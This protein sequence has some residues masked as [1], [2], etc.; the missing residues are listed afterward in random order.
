MREYNNVVKPGVCCCDNPTCLKI[1]YSHEGMFT[2]PYSDKKGNKLTTALQCLGVNEATK[3]HILN[4]PGKYRV[5]P[6][7][8]SPLHRE[9]K[10]GRWHLIKKECYID[11]N[12][13]E[14]NVPPPNYD[15]E[16]YIKLEIP[17]K[18]DDSLPEWAPDFITKAREAHDERFAGVKH[19]TETGAELLKQ[20]KEK[21]NKKS[22]DDK[23]HNA[24]AKDDT[25]ENNDSRRDDVV[26]ITDQ[27][28]N[29]QLKLNQANNTIQNL[30][31]TLVQKNTEIQSQKREL[32]EYRLLDEMMENSPALKY[33]KREVKLKLNRTKSQHLGEENRKSNLN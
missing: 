19:T 6:W 32:E 2:L 9:Y 22:P 8:Y 26:P 11:E 17:G 16:Q 1:G 28:V 21:G 15:L 31:K 14:Y 29:L 3:S 4:N 33:Q 23:V 7:H 27:V 5:A 10:N 18:N 20:I 25:A 12:G 13:M 30:M 24:K